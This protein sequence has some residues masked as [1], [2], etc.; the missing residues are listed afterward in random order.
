MF[1]LFLFLFSGEDVD[2]GVHKP[3]GLCLSSIFLTQVSLCLI[4][5]PETISIRDGF[6]NS[7]MIAIL[8]KNVNKLSLHVKSILIRSYFVLHLHVFISKLNIVVFWENILSIL[9]SPIFVRS[10]SLNTDMKVEL[11]VRAG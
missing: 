3:I 6:K 1:L 2:D 11:G 9:P 10:S 4:S 8:I 7:G 5:N